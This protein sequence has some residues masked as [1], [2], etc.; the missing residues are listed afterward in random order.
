[1]FIGYVQKTALVSIAALFL[2]TGTAHALD[3]DTH[4]TSDLRAVWRG[5]DFGDQSVPLPWPRPNA[6]VLTYPGESFD[7]WERKTRSPMPYQESQRYF[8][9]KE[10]F[11]GLNLTPSWMMTTRGSRAAG[12]P[13]PTPGSLPHAEMLPVPTDLQIARATVDRTPVYTRDGRAMA[14]YSTMPLPGFE[15]EAF[16]NFLRNQPPST[17]IEDRRGEIQPTLQPGEKPAMQR[18]SGIV[19]R[20]K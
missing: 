3:C 12:A 15:G 17:N 18:A 16:Y 6:P 20:K 5:G 8:S 4:H 1:M 10:A 11:P 14:P 19:T 2:T 7:A 13:S 9:A